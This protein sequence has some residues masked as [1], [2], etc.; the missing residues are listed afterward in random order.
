MH[1]ICLNFILQ[2]I[3]ILDTNPLLEMHET[4][5]YG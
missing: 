5:H 2:A 3:I 1:F 4:K